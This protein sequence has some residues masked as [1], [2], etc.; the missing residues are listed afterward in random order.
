MRYKTRRQGSRLPRNPVVDPRLLVRAGGALR[1]FGGATLGYTIGA[2]RFRALRRF[3]IRTAGLAF[4]VF[5]NRP[6]NNRGATSKFM[7]LN[8]AAFYQIE[9]FRS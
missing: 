8:F 9:D 3:K 6:S 5:V 2:Y 4:D 7:C 1:L